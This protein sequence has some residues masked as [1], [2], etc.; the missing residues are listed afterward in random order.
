MMKKLFFT[1]FVA[2]IFGTSGFSQ[3]QFGGGIS[4]VASD[5]SAIGVGLKT[6]FDVTDNLRLGPSFNYYFESGSSYSVDADLQYKLATIGDN[7]L[8]YPFTGLNF[9]NLNGL[10]VEVGVNLGVHANFPVTDILNVYI[11]P[12]YVTLSDADGFA[13]AAGI[14]F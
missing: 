11:E 5:G 1:L 10:G 3:T 14:F 12:K 9:A 4:F 13:I 7:T 8:I 2:C 6:A